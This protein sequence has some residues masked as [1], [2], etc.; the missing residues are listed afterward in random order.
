MAAWTESPF[1]QA[2]G[3]ATLNS[4]WQMALLWAV[5]SCFNYTF[6]LSATLKYKA[7]VGAILIGFAWFVFTA[8][9]YY[10]NHSTSYA[11]FQNTIVHSN[12]LLHICLLS[13]SVTY[14]LLLVFPAVRLFYNWKFVQRIKVEGQ[15]KAHLE[16]R[17]FV[18]KVS[19]LLG[20]KKKVKVAVSS[21]VNSPVTVGYLKP[22]ILLPVAAMNNL[23]AAQV[24][25]ILLHELSHIR[26]YDY[27]LNFVV[28]VIHTLLYFNPFVKSFITVIEAER[29][30]CCDEIVLQF[31]YD[32]VGYA[33]ALLHLEQTGGRQH[34]LAMAAAGKQNLL[35]RIEKIVGMEKKKTFK[36]V[37]I[38]PLFLAMFC[39]LLFN[40][41][42]I[43]KDAG[44]GA[45]MAYAND[46]VFSPFPLNGDA[47]KNGLKPELLPASK[48]RDF[49]A[50]VS[51]TELPGNDAVK[52]EVFNVTPTAGEPAMPP[53]SVPAA[54]HVIP[55][56]FDETDA[57]LTTEEKEKVKSTVETTKQLAGKLTWKEIETA[58][59]DAMTDREKAYAHQEY[60]TEFEKVGWN[61]MK[62]NMEAEF[63][64][65]DWEK[66]DATIASAKN[67]V[68]LDSIH[69]VYAQTY[70]ALEKAQ[71]NLRVK[72]K[73]AISPLPDAS[74]DQLQLAKESLR[75]N[76]DELKVRKEKKSVCL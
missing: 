52:I 14:L 32:K 47:Q 23:S 50:K 69:S 3:W 17:L 59:G 9:F 67:M 55:A 12:S 5:Y 53:E 19:F 45:A 25:A 75:K 58:I 31:G 62:K 74:V 72:S 37:Q 61:N 8:V 54:D 11:F 34:P 48:S 68:Q 44:T 57:N 15:Q 66:V 46:T 29:E 6:K 18:H 70:Q 1:L 39:V 41:V 42:L 22:V 38:V 2:L 63:E 21:L 71:K 35:T 51:Y 40:S 20:I 65:I 30:A 13:A 76:L 64:N 24:E 28:S 56:A 4:L 49:S 7:S 16:Y 27:L 26:R 36:L 60:I 10:Q 73:C 33:S 43:I